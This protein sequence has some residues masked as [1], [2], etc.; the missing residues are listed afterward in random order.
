MASN[1]LQMQ[2]QLD[3]HRAQMKIKHA[4]F[5]SGVKSVTN[6][7]QF[8][9]NNNQIAGFPPSIPVGTW[10]LN[11][12]NNND[13]SLRARGALP[14]DFKDYN[15]AYPNDFLGDLAWDGISQALNP[16]LNPVY[17][18]NGW[19][20]FNQMVEVANKA[21][22]ELVR[23]INI[24]NRNKGTSKSSETGAL[25]YYNGQ[26]TAAKVKV[27]KLLN[28]FTAEASETKIKRA[29][30][31]KVKAELDKPKPRPSPTLKPLPRPKR[32]RR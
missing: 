1:P 29:E 4:E 15:M 10:E 5:M 18:P 2:Q 31:A 11:V 27:Q 26:W 22:D 32:R 16:D 19:A 23:L 14:S 13:P 25:G 3:A 8:K 30:A 6:G 21:D 28:K 24:R 12:R 7:T 9:W 20:L 17:L